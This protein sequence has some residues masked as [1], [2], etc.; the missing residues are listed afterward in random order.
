EALAASSLTHPNIVQLFDFGI[1]PK[2]RVPYIAMEYVEGRTL[3]KL[4]DDEGPLPET[5][6]AQLLVQVAKALAEAHATG[7]VHRDLK[8][9]NVMVTKLRAG[10]E[11]VKVVDF[12]IAK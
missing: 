5:R 1:E 10:D 6:V 8:A 3:G 12:G 9:D 7:I 2:L 11:H 4:L